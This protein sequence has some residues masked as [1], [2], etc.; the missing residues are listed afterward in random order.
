[1]GGRGGEWYCSGGGATEPTSGGG[2]CV[3][4][5][6]VLL[7]VFTLAGV[8]FPVAAHF[9]TNLDEPSQQCLRYELYIYTHAHYAIIAVVV[10]MYV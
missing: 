2:G 9:T 7:F 4:V 1:M 5:A 6:V 3:H 8:L 10:S